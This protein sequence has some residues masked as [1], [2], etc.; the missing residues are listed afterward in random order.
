MQ[1]QFWKKEG[2]L[3]RYTENIFKEE[4]HSRIWA[5]D[6]SAS[7]DQKAG[8]SISTKFATTKK[9]KKDGFR[10]VLCIQTFG[11]GFGWQGI[12]ACDFQS[13][14]RRYWSQALI[15]LCGTSFKNAFLFLMANGNR[16]IKRCS[17]ACGASHWPFEWCHWDGMNS[18]GTLVLASWN[19]CS[20][21][22]HGIK[23]ELPSC[24]RPL[25]WWISGPWMTSI[26]WF[27]FFSFLSLSLLT[28]D[29]RILNFCISLKTTF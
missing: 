22:V 29:N 5:W 4:P 17:C 10:P 6:A 2:A 19:L 16:S 14:D 13:G 24:K 3:S 25:A 18:A 7:P 15:S 1:V 11:G 28:Y 27:R 21:W 12:I 8:G 26:A 23:M 20:S 9:K